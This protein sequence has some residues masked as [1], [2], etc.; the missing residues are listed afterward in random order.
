MAEKWNTIGDRTTVRVFDIRKGGD[1]R[2]NWVS[3]DRKHTPALDYQPGDKVYLDA[4]DIQ[5]TQPSKKLSHH[6]LGPFEVIKKVGNGIYHLK[7]PQ[8]MSHLHPVF[9]VVKLTSALSDPIAGH[10]LKP[11]PLP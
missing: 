10:H 6:C 7:L 1:W 8:S 5:A 9:N 2:W 3:P 11:P 4:S